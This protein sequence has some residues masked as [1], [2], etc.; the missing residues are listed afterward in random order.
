MPVAE[1]IVGV[2][3]IQ[4]TYNI[5]KRKYFTEYA[6][7]RVYA[8]IVYS[9]IQILILSCSQNR[10]T[11]YHQAN[12]TKSALEHAESLCSFSKHFSLRR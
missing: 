11:I 10:S 1:N 7:N 12:K 8:T 4:Q 6:T 9:C 5:E 2:L 3:T